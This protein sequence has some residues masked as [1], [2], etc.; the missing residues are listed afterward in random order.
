LIDVHTFTDLFLSLRALG[1]NHQVIDDSYEHS[2][3]FRPGQ[4]ARAILQIKITHPDLMQ[5]LYTKHYAH[6]TL[7]T[8]LSSHDLMQAPLLHM[9]E[10]V[11]RSDGSL[12]KG[13]CNAAGE[14]DVLRH[15]QG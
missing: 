10:E 13:T 1:T 9:G 12:A 6:C 2:I 4:K 5:V 8:V 11:V 14:C 3:S 7:C 15:L